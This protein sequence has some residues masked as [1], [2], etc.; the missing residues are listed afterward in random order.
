MD[1]PQILVL[2]VIAALYLLLIPSS[3]RG[4]A[5]MVVSA[6]AIYWLQPTISVRWL[7]YSLPSATLLLTMVCWWVSKPSETR[8]PSRQDLL[9]G[10]I[11][12]AIIV[13]L[14]LARYMDLPE[15]LQLTSRPPEIVGVAL[16]IALALGIAFS[17]RQVVG[18][19]SLVI[20]LVVVIGL[21]VA[22]QTPPLAEALSAFLR[23]QSGQ[24]ISLAS[25]LDLNWLG[26]S[27]VAFRLIHTLRDR[28]T[29]I[30]PDLSLRDYVTY[31]VFAP[32]YASGPIDRAERFT[33]DLAAL[34]TMHGFDAP[35]IT[36]ALARIGVGM[37]KKFVIADSLAVFSLDAL[38]ATQAVNA[39]ATWVMLYAYGFRL[40][41]DFSGYTDIAIGIGMLFGVQ[42]PENFDRPYLKNNITAFWQAWHMSLTNWVRFYIFSPLSRNLLRR[43]PKPSNEV[44][45]FICH[46]STMLIIGLWHSVTLPFLL[47][48][49]WHG[50]GLW[51]HKLWTDRTRKWYM[52]LKNTPR[53]KQAWTFAGWFLTFHFVMLGWVWFSMPTVDMALRVFAQLVGVAR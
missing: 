47:W 2:L 44:I 10:G 51:V 49:V 4:W 33:S 35:R 32:A 46:L 20:G 38:N 24:D 9:A 1:F 5:L 26:F 23:G 53:K 13:L 28:Q 17:V 15:A 18:S 50:L 19:R 6:V 48:G 45:M 41:F 16:A 25:S 27:Y 40:F 21:L 11:V 31:V 8:R 12:V 36:Q 42:L 7:D 22:M 3:W 14:G 43:D 34:P 39:G 30:L 29:G 37:F 52:G